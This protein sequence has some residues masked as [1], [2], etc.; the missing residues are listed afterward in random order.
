[1]GFTSAQN[2]KIWNGKSKTDGWDSLRLPIEVWMHKQFEMRRHIGEE[3]VI[4]IGANSID[5][6][7]CRFACMN[8]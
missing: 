1:M 3:D 4:Y 2:H 8:R 7:N 5:E 6:M